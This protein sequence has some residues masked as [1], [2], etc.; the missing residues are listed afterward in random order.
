MGSVE[1]HRKILGVCY[2]AGGSL[3]VII[4]IAYLASHM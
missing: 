3:F 4:G 1:T 2:T